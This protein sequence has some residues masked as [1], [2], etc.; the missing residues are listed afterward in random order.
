[1]V[2]N[3]QIHFTVVAW[4]ANRPLPFTSTSIHGAGKQFLGVTDEDRQLKQ[5]HLIFVTLRH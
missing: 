1:M 2:G 3:I 4:F 5:P